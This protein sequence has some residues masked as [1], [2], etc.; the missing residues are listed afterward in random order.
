MRKYIIGSVSALDKPLTPLMKGIVGTARFFKKI[1]EKLIQAHSEEVMSSK[2]EHIRDI[3]EMVAAVLDKE[4]ICVV[5]NE[6]K[7]QEEESIFGEIIPV[8]N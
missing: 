7:L 3:T 6:G 5:G 2:P 8:F 4:V 1:D